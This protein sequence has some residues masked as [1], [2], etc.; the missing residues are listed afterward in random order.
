MNLAELRE[1]MDKLETSL[2]LKTFPLAIKM[3]KREADIPEGARRPLRHLGYHL[4]TC[5]VF[6]MSRRQGMT[7]AQLREDMWCF[8]PVVGYGLGEPPADFLRGNNRFPDTARTPEAGR[9][10]A[11]AFPRFPADQYVGIVTAP[12]KVINFDPDLILIYCDPS[13]LTSLLTIKNWIDG[14]DVSCRLSGHASCVFSVVPPIQ[15]NGWQVTSPSRGD[16]TRAMAADD[17][18]MLSIP[19]SAF[20]DISAGL[21]QLRERKWTPPLPL[22][23]CPEYEMPLNSVRLGRQMGMTWVK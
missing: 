20:E 7:L 8:E 22:T 11:Q 4:S 9:Q 14:V 18:M 1:A 19:P 6:S 12:A 2:R 15:T 10:W 23:L 17:E 5:Q 21:E 16:R 13:Q 3:L